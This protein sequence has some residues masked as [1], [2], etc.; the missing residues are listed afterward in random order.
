M[1]LQLD[2]TSGIQFN[3]GSD[4]STAATPYGRKNLIINGDMRIAQRGTSTTGL[5]YNND[6]NY[7]C[8]DRWKFQ[9]FGSTSYTAAFTGSQDTDV[10]SG[11]GFVSSLKLACTTADA[12]LEA[13]TAVLF[14]QQLEAQNL[15]HLKYGTSSAEKITL[16]FW[17]KSN[18]TGTFTAVVQHGETGDYYGVDYTIDTADTWQKQTLSIDGNTTDVINNDNGSGLSLRFY[19]A[20]GSDYASGTN[21]QWVS[22]ASVAGIAPNMTN[23]IGGSTSNYINI[24]GVQLEV[25]DAASDFE[26]MPFDMELARCQRY[27]S[28][29]YNYEDAVGTNT[30]DG[31]L[32]ARNM[33]SV[34]RSDFPINACFPV[35]MRANPTITAYSKSGIA[36]RRTSNGTSID[37]STSEII[38]VSFVGNSK[39]IRGMACN[40]GANAG[41]FVQ[42]HYIAEAEL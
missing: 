37:T 8:C 3:D 36:G 16:S 22:S 12:T 14:A 40:S 24:T 6:N 42:A 11:Q 38:N 25:G 7:P 2:G 20:V 34:A 17:V 19:L 4:Q 33:D 28:K 9:E 1:S 10:P 27:F 23:N 18:L 26:F 41:T 35:E 15:Q 29:S 5:Q 21:G 39:C 30:W 13:D 31:T 32:A